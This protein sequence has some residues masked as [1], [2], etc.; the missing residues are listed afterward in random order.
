MGR[1][2]AVRGLVPMRELARLQFMQCADVARAAA[3]VLGAHLL[4]EGRLAAP[5]EVFQRTTGRSRRI[6]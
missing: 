1:M 6:E 4:R 5:D 3:T 2:G